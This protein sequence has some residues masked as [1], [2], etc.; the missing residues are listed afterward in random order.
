MSGGFL[1]Q[2]IG[3]TIQS[4]NVGSFGTHPHAQD[5]GDLWYA[6]SL[7]SEIHRRFNA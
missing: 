5:L 1:A 2:H 4:G 3:I 7:Q 6:D